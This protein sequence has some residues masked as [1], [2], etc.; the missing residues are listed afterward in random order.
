MLCECDIEE[1]KRFVIVVYVKMA[2]ERDNRV[3]I[4]ALLRAGH[5]VSKIANLV[6]VS[7]TTVYVIKMRVDDG[8]GF[9]RCAGS[10]WKTVVYRDSLRDAIRESDSD[11]IP[12]AAT[13]HSSLST[14]ACTSVDTFA[15]FHALLDCVNDCARLTRSVTEFHLFIEFNRC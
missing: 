8:K 4:F 12:Q 11:D 3:K 15:I 1:K 10:G 2:S 9:N 5:K 6:W 7:S 13:I 14:T